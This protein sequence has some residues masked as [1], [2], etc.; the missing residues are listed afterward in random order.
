MEKDERVGDQPVGVIDQHGLVVLRGMVASREIRERAEEIARGQAGVV[1]VINELEVEGEP[2]LFPPP[3][4]P[5]VAPPGGS[6][7]L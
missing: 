4:P 3:P 6:H 5:H 7:Y 2:D 1:D